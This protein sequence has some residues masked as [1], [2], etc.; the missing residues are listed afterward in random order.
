MKNF[1]F[2]FILIFHFK[3]LLSQNPCDSLEA[4]FDSTCINVSGGVEPYNFLWVDNNNG[5]SFICNSEN[6]CLLDCENYNF[7]PGNYS[8]VVQDANQCTTSVSFLIEDRYSF[9]EEIDEARD[10]KRKKLAY[11]EAVA[12]AKQHLEGLK[13]KYYEELKL[14]S[15]LTSEQQKAINFFN[16]SFS[17]L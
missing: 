16:R 7:C 13:G 6:G 2:F 10:V 4:Y 14:G 8:V 17:D 9:D 12:E 11:K 3:S 1:F 5:F 15:K